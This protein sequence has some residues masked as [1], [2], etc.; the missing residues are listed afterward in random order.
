MNIASQFSNTL[1]LYEVFDYI[2]NKQE[3]CFNDPELLTYY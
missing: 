2:L 3:D 1:A